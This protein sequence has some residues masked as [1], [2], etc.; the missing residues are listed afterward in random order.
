MPDAMATP[1]TTTGH[2][3]TSQTSVDALVW[4]RVP[5]PS[6]QD[7]LDRITPPGRRKARAVIWWEP[8]DTW[9]PVQ[10]WMI[11][12]VLPD[13]AT[14]PHILQQLKGPH[15]RSS[16]RYSE[17]IGQWVDGPAPDISKTQWDIHQRY[18]GWALPY[19]VLQ[20]E[21]GGHR[22]KLFPWEQVL[23]H[24]ATGRKDVAK[25]GELP[26]CE[27]DQ[28]TWDA[29]WEAKQRTDEAMKVAALATKYR[30]QL[31]MEDAVMVEK[32]A[33][34]FV[35]SW[36]E[37]ISQHADEFAW[38]LRR[39]PSMARATATAEELGDA[40]ADE[41]TLVKELMHDWTGNLPGYNDR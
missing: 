26:A 39:N 33:R 17:K 32:A 40:H 4:T 15:P 12:Q 41:E 37:S 34:Q 11:Y 28:R 36:G 9:E 14:P 27:P 8:G 23:L 22:Y 18:G 7:T 35:A 20:G 25:P 21:N 38:A 13:A 3:P 1:D 24:L 19:W 2:D 10:R 29:L 30:G 6:W 31:D 5:P 16:G